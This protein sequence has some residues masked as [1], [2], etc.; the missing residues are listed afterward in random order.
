MSADELS[1]LLDELGKR[2]GPTGQH[3]FDLAIRQVIIDGA[4]GVGLLALFSI[5]TIVMVPRVYR[6]TKGGDG[7]HSDDRG[8]VAS[9]VGLVWS[10]VG[11]FVLLNGIWE[12]SRL[13]NPEYAALRDILGAIPR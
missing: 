13:L 12:L 6:W 1:K 9:I 11:A 4:I 10:I 8:M 5:A 2:L 3:V 7:Y